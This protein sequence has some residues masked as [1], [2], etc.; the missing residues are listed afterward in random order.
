MQKCNEC[1]ETVLTSNS[2][3]IRLALVIR[4]PSRLSLS[5]WNSRWLPRGG[6][7][8]HPRR[9]PWPTDYSYSA[10]LCIIRSSCRRSRRNGDGSGGGGLERQME[11][12]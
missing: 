3:I 4:A 2:T 5:E 1:P 11:N 12:A 10:R 9:T 6:S 8:I 7:A